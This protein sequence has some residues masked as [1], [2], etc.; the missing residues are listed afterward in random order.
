MYQPTVGTQ[1]LEI[2][3]KVLHS[4]DNIFSCLLDE[5]IAKILN[6]KNIFRSLDLISKISKPITWIISKSHGEKKKK[7]K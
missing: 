4:F 7:K 5:W 6:K 3:K 1:S 2:G